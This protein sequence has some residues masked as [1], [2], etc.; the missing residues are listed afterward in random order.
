[1]TSAQLIQSTTIDRRI[2][3]DESGIR[4]EYSS[5]RI[6]LQAAQLLKLHGGALL[7][8]L[9]EGALRHS[10]VK[11][12]LIERARG[13]VTIV[14]DGVQRTVRQALVEIARCL[15]ES[16]RN[17]WTADAALDLS[18]VSGP[19]IRV[20]RVSYEQALRKQKKSTRRPLLP[21]KIL[22][23]G[24]SRLVKIAAAGGCLLVA[25]AGLVLPSVPTLSFSLAAGYF[26]IR[27]SPALN[28]RLRNSQAFGSVVRDFQDYGGMRASLKSE[29]VA[30]ALA[31]SGAAILMSGYSL[32]AI[33]TIAVAMIDLCLVLRLPTIPNT[34]FA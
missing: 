29:V 24:P 1:M 7:I 12:V 2:N 9:V 11:S 10:A 21:Y 8:E 32:A 5:G 19:L 22:A 15:C 13:T 16:R 33:A 4:V 6:T 26:L 25:V 20:D 3:R 23:M 27:S 28:E 18:A 17:D 14:Y 34:V 31:T 30:L